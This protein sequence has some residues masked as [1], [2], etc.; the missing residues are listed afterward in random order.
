[1]LGRGEKNKEP[2]KNTDLLSFGAL[3]GEV[4]SVVVLLELSKRIVRKLSLYVIIMEF[5]LMKFASWDQCIKT[6]MNQKHLLFQ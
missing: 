1:M 5:S 3:S 2:N 6:Q 4:F